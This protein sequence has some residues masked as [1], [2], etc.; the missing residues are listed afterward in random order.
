MEEK[1]VE[2]I[3]PTF[4]LAR[5]FELWIFSWES[6]LPQPCPGAI[7]QTLLSYWYK[8]QRWH[9]NINSAKLRKSFSPIK[10]SAK[11]KTHIAL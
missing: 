9:W 6:L 10:A 1:W 8:L 3:T 2:S 7:T 4:S 11:E 5:Y